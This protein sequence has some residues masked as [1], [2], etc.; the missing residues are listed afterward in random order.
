MQTGDKVTVQYPD[1]PWHAGEELE[2]KYGPAKDRHGT[3]AFWCE[4]HGQYVYV[5]PIAVTYHYQEFPDH[6]VE[7]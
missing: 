2:F 5:R 3:M 1:M 4:N 6:R 7:R